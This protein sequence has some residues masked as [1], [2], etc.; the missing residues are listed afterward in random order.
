MI[1]IMPTIGRHKLVKQSVS[2]FLSTSSN[3]RILVIGDGEDAPPLV[4]HPRV[5][6]ARTDERAGFWSALNYGLSIV[7][8]ENIYGFFGNDVIFT[9]GWEVSVEQCFANHFPQGK[10]LMAVRDGVWDSFHASHGFTTK[11]FLEVL[12]G[13]PLFPAAYFHYY[14]DGELTQFAKDLGRFKYCGNAY[15]KHLHHDKG[16][17]ELDEVDALPRTNVFISKKIYDERYRAWKNGGKK[18]ARRRL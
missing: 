3:A 14:A 11:A 17:R 9:S 8:D 13:K 7:P 2:T 4:E 16:L 18:E 10:G 12:Y 6:T 5:M 1:V 15:I